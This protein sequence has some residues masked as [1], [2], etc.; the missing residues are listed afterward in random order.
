MS[1]RS[2]WSETRRPGNPALEQG[3]GEAITASMWLPQLRSEAGV[4]QEELAKRLGVTQSW[5]LQYRA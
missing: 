5:V 2:K 3:F 1:G 4:T